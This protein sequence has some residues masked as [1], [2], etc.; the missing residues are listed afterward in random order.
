MSGKNKRKQSAVRSGT[1]KKINAGS[2]MRI[3]Q[4]PDCTGSSG[5]ITAGSTRPESSTS[6]ATKQ[7]A[8]EKFLT[9]LNDPKF[10]KGAP[11]TEVQK[12]FT[13]RKQK[14]LL[15]KVI[16][17]LSLESRIQLSRAPS[18][19][20]L[21]YILIDEGM[22]AKYA[23]L[24]VQAKLVLQ[25][26]EK[27]GNTGIWTKEVRLQTNIQQQALTKIFKQLE[28]RELIKPI[29]S[30]A[31]K[32]KKLY[33][34]FDLEPSKEITGGI[35]YSGLEF[36]HEFISEL[37]TFVMHC[38][39]RLNHGTGVTVKEILSKMEEAKVSRVELSIGEIKQL[40][41]TLVY[42]YCI[43]EGPTPT[44]TGEIRYVLSRPVTTPIASFKWWDC[45]SPDFH[46]RAIKFQ[47][48]VTLSAHEP[49][50]HTI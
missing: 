5:N 10:S 1:G 43:E 37:R 33:M 48:G 19:N 36:D 25:C 14:E 45:L 16:N 50:H 41:Q 8:K 32:S 27:A 3:K 11:N 21:F 20:E 17:E 18:T 23:G 12:H 40:V 44:S 47:D 46:F 6:T 39:K 49:H 7:A 30:I 38:A 9:I 24:D 28:S 22:A 4:E 15:V 31:A 42:D 34:L 26:V 35:W 13:D 29:K 2:S